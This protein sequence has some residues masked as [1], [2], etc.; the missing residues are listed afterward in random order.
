[1]SQKE[2]QAAA[3]AATS[4]SD[5]ESLMMRMEADREQLA[6][7]IL[8]RLNG[9]AQEGSSSANSTSNKP[10]KSGKNV[11][12]ELKQKMRPASLGVGAKAPTTQGSHS[13][14]GPSLAQ[15]VR[16]KGRLTSKKR[17]NDDLDADSFAGGP[18]K[19]KGK[20]AA[21]EDE[22][23]EAKG[24]GQ[25]AAKKQKKPQDIFAAAA[26]KAQKGKSAQNNA[27]AAQGAGDNDDEDG[28]SHGLDGLDL[29]E[30]SK[31]QRKKLRKR[32]ADAHAASSTERTN[33]LET[34]E[35][36]AMSESNR[37]AL[38]QKLAS[39]FPNAA[40]ATSPSKSSD[41]AAKQEKAKA[42]E[43]KPQA[44][45]A[46]KAQAVNPPATQLTKLQTQ[47]STS[48]AGARFRHIN[49]KLYTTTSQEALRMMQEDP[50]LMTDYH[51]GFASQTT[52]WPVNPVDSIAGRLREL[53]GVPAAKGKEG[54]K[55]SNGTSAAKQENKGPFLVADLG[56]GTAP[57]AKALKG[58]PGIAV[59]SYDLL[60]SPDGYVVGCD[61]GSHVPL[62]GRK[63]G[64]VSRCRTVIQESR[65][66]KAA[67][68]SRQ[69]LEAAVAQGPEAVDACVF[70]LSLMGTNWVDMVIEARRI[71]K[72]K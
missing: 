19:G 35:L 20:A 32:V 38:Q 49:E 18:N 47:M 16:L 41:A 69:A 26:Q 64:I 6:Q 44:E 55:A 17:K 30:L 66:S 61:V 58:V 28:S 4:A 2:D 22:E 5:V 24:R 50:Q 40:A 13:A 59:L 14:A 57:L 67:A 42:V 48:L 8:S 62:P 54:K 21:D 45:A 33:P 11:A 7:R 37:S 71:M 15:D 39:L 23:D 65:A 60:D 52:K 53:A 63:G 12:Q 25:G 70:S 72:H 43:P 1:M 34:L 27:A 68:L 10:P 31:K 3:P 56:A 36:G 51:S 9:G 46:T 29:S